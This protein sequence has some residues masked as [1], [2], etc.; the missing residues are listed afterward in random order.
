MTKSINQAEELKPASRKT[1]QIN[2]NVFVEFRS[3]FSGH[4]T[5]VLNG[6][7]MVSVHVEDRGIHHT[8]NVRAVGRWPGNTGISG[9]SNLNVYSEELHFVCSIDWLI[10]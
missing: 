7:R 4:L 6:L 8:R 2:D 10:K 9:E 1:Y 5:D 3:P